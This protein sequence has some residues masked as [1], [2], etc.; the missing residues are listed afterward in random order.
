MARNSG[1]GRSGPSR[2]ASVKVKTA[3][4]RK[5]SSTRWLQRQLN[6]PYVQ[7]AQRLGFR[8]RAAFKLQWLDEK[9]RLFRRGARVVDLGAAPG[10]WTQVAV[11]AVGAEGRVVALD[12]NDFEPVAGA[13]CL[14]G[15][16]YDPEIDARIRDALGGPADVVM[17]DMAA[18]STGHAVT[19]HLRVMALL[20]AAYEIARPLLKPGGAFV[21]KILQGGTERELLTMLKRDF[22]KVVHAKPDASRK[23]SSE[24]Y[25]VA[26]GFRGS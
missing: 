19:D 22:A 2:R 25:L 24:M 5:I 8:S 20:E 4:G 18:P 21:G 23:D 6:D 11:A 16:V 26:T 10:G 17:S 9:Y 12:L 13:E 15:D 14:T 7:E 1:R 3:R